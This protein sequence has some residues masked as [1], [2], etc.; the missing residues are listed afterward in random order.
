MVDSNLEPPRTLKMVEDI[1]THREV[2]IRGILLTLKLPDWELADHIPEYLE[3]VRSWGYR[4][5]RARQLAFNRHELCIAALPDRGQRRAAPRRRRQAT[6]PPR[7]K[8]SE[9]E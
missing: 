4:Y 8:R 1:V 6:T 5:V 9:E 2:N 3:R 7:Q